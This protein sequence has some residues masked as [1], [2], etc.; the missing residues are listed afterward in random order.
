MAKAPTAAKAPSGFGMEEVTR[1]NLQPAVA[2]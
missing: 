1:I 2:G